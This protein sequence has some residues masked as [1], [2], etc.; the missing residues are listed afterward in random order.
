[1]IIDDFGWNINDAGL[2]CTLGIDF[3][4]SSS[5]SIYPNPTKRILYIEKNQNPVNISIYNLLGKEVISSNSTN[6]IDVNSLSNGV[7]FITIIDGINSSTIKFI[8]E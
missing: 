7:Y 6:R 8:K 4:T 3:I 5:V 1:M 2:D